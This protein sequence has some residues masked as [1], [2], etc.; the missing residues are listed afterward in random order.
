[1]HWRDGLDSNTSG[2]LRDENL[3]VQYVVYFS[4]GFRG[5]V[6]VN[7]FLTILLWPLACLRRP[8]PAKVE[9]DRFPAQ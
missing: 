7:G 5:L 2:P 8:T 3:D 9:A 4:V 6:I 1:V